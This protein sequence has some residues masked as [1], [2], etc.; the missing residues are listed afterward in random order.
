[1]RCMCIVVYSALSEMTSNKTFFKYCALPSMIGEQTCKCWPKTVAW[2]VNKGA[3]TSRTA[4]GDR[5]LTRV[6]DLRALMRDTLKK[7]SHRRLRVS[8]K[9]LQ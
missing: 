3:F 5:P 2:R 1:M 8:H 9:S 4:G 6:G 7:M